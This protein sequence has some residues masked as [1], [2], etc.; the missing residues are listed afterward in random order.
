MYANVPHLLCAC[1]CVCVCSTHPLNNPTVLFGED[2]RIYWPRVGCGLSNGKVLIYL[3]A[4]ITFNCYVPQHIPRVC[5]TPAAYTVVS[6]LCLFWQ[7]ITDDVE[8]H[9][10]PLAKEKEGTASNSWVIEQP[11]KNKKT[12]TYYER[13]WPH[14]SKCSKMKAKRLTPL[15]ETGTA[16]IGG[17]QLMGSNKYASKRWQMVQ[18]GCLS[19]VWASHNEKALLPCNT[20]EQID[21]AFHKP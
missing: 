13:G 17:W 20:N 5:S 19:L 9:N 12:C 1:V 18:E 21:Q 4:T 7:T 11:R 2:P 8:W 15:W 16:N 14:R 6:Q 3:K 10:H